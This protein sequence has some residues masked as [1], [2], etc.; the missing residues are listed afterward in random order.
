[1]KSFERFCFGVLAAQLGDE[2]RVTY[3]PPRLG[4][5]IRRSSL[6]DPTHSTLF[7]YAASRPP[8]WTTSIRARFSR[9]RAARTNVSEGLTCCDG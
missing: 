1:M 7:T 4:G 8:P 2:E 3:L 6:L 9:S 5:K